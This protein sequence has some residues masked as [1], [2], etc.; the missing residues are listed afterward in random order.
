MTVQDEEA[1]LAMTSTADPISGS[2]AVLEKETAVPT[3]TTDTKVDNTTQ[4]LSALTLDAKRDEPTP[5]KEFSATTSPNVSTDPVWPENPADHPLTKFFA[6][7]EELTKQAEYAEVYGISL[8]TSDPFHTKLILQKFLRAN[9]NDLEK[10]KQQ[11]LETLQWRK[12]FDPIKAISETYDKSRFGGLGYVL[13]IEGVPESVNKKDVVTFNIYGAVKDKKATFGDLEGFL[14]WRVGLMEKSVQ[15]LN[16][17]E[18]TKPIPDFGLG[19]D[20]YQ[21]YQIHDYLQVSFLRQDPSKLQSSTSAM[22]SFTDV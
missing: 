1:K 3:S 9:A 14:R 2:S 22:G 21:G 13:E 17:K 7:F 10:A 18:A 15:K 16:L 4:D 19:P 5:P 6:S 8:S 12:S 20:P 11:L